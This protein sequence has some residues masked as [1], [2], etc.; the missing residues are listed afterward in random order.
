MLASVSSAFAQSWGREQRPRA[1]ACFYEDVDYRGRYFCTPSGCDIAD[2]PKGMNDR[3]S[4]I[5]LFGNAEV[6][7]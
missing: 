7:L 6:T 3:I 4:S 5:Q 1:G 2:L